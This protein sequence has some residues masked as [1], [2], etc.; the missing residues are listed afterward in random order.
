MQFHFHANQS[1]FHKNGCALRLALKQRHKG[2]R[3]WPIN[4]AVRL[5]K[6]Y[7]VAL[8]CSFFHPS[9]YSLIQ[10]LTHPSI[11]PS[12]LVFFPSFLLSFLLSSLFFFLSS[13]LFP[14]LLSLIPSIHLFSLPPFLPCILAF[15]LSLEIGFM[16]F[17][18]FFFHKILFHF[19]LTHCQSPS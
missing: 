9:I 5:N 17:H 6:H 4:V 7:F 12:I 8:A 18:L 2:T 1:H 11:Y 10:L 13:T 16:R 15:F 3:K 14:Y 19:L